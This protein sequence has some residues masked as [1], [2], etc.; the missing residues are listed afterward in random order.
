VDFESTAIPGYAISAAGIRFSATVISM[1]LPRSGMEIHLK[2]RDYDVKIDLKS[3][4]TLRQALTK[5]KI[6]PSMVIVSHDGVILPH[7]TVLSQP[8]ELLVTTIS[9][10]G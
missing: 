8:V 5:A 6:L 2:G 10:G 1:V 3:G 7:A 9:S 4:Q